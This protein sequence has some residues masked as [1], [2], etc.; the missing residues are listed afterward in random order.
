[1]ESKLIFWR[2][3]AVFMTSFA[4]F[5]SICIGGALFIIGADG[6][7]EISVQRGNWMEYGFKSAAP[8]LFF[9]GI[10]CFICLKVASRTATLWA[11]SNADRDNTRPTRKARKSV[12]VKKEK[13][14]ITAGGGAG[15]L[16]SVRSQSS[17][18]DP[19]GNRGVLI[20]Y[21]PQD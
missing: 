19:L 1:M 2:G 12:R 4:G 13:T 18:T 21:K 17:P 15:G 6:S 9:A 20:H 5:A 11:E 3:L 7:F 14:K 16:K 8:G 10:G